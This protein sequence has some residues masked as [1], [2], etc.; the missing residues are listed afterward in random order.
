MNTINANNY[1]ETKELLKR[2]LEIDN[3][4]VRAKTKDLLA[5]LKDEIEKYVKK[6]WL[7]DRCL[8]NRG[9]Y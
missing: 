5:K 8:R 9:N 1:F 6:R 4:E 2:V 3:G 7:G